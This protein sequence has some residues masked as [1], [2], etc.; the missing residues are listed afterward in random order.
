[1]SSRTHLTTSTCL[2]PPAVHEGYYQK[3]RKWPLRGYHKRYFLLTRGLL[4][5]G[6]SRSEVE[7]WEKGGKYHGKVDL[8][9]AAMT[10]NSTRKRRKSFSPPQ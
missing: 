10:R 7:R 1:M 9:L 4:V 6:K 8:G 3:K 2:T 5:Y